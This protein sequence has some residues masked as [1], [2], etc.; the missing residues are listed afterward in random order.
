[1][2]VSMSKGNPDY[3]GFYKS[4]KDG[5]ELLL[6]VPKNR[7]IRVIGHLD[8]DGICASAIMISALIKL[9]RKYSLTI[10]PTITEESLIDIRAEDDA[11]IVF[12]DLGSGMIDI[13]G[14]VLD[15]KRVFIL[16][17]HMLQSV[18]SYQNVT[19]LNPH[20][21][22]IDGSDEIS[23]AGVVFLFTQFLTGDKNI[24]MS[25]IA[26]V[27][28]IG[29]IQEHDGFKR[30]NN[31]ILDIAIK[32]NLIEVRRGLKFF[33]IQTKPLYKLLQYSSDII[34]PGVTGSES[35][36]ISFLQNIG[37]EPKSSKGWRKIADLTDEEKKNLIAAIIVKRINKTGSTQQDIF[38]NTYLLIGEGEDTPFRDA[39]EFATLL[40]SCGRL[41]RASIGI[42]ACLNDK[43]MKEMAVSNLL[44]YRK[45]LVNALNWYR[46]NAN[47][48][49]IVKKKRYIIINAEDEVMPTIIGT[50]GS[51]LSK[52]QDIEKNTFILSLA[53]NH[54]DTTKISL[55]IT[56]N[57]ESINLKEIIE[58][59]ISK[60]GH[61]TSG[62]H[63]FAAG[64]VIDTEFEEQFLK[65]ANEVLEGILIEESI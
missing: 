10:L 7:N 38:T 64:A 48:D 55:R 21:Y 8:A 26:V 44:D 1:M 19:Q 34:I 3:E 65:A 61:G 16:D 18:A 43:K 51:I 45:E 41:N 35:G 28:A 50:L 53:R 29:D 47:T 20:M 13:I 11:H 49:R 12:V 27:G 36:A 9:N 39:K 2:Q 22:D 25:R 15:N 37:I 23:G 17:H 60:V 24:E 58:G 59:I 5:S 14:K 6:A 4:L 54:D 30:L 63:S 46:D 31:S 33:G 52:S 57:P 40:N 62:G 32:N 42:G 56:G